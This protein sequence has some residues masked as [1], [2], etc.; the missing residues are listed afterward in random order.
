MA[1][2]S[3]CEAC[4]SQL[5]AGP[6]VI[7]A[8]GLRIDRGWREAT[9]KGVDLKLAKQPFAI[10]ELLLLNAGGLVRAQTLFAYCGT[11]RSDTCS[12]N[13]QVCRI[14]KALDAIEPGARALLETVHGLGF[15]WT[16]RPFS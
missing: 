16:A 5:D 8:G 6:I 15:K 3:I 11:D 10:L 7:E 1:R 13:V 12:L 14:R 9:F 4:G 2:P